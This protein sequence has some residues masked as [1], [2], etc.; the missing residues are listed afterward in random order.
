M[1]HRAG[2]DGNERQTSTNQSTQSRLEGQ[3]TE[4]SPS[5]GFQSYHRPMR[6]GT[7]LSKSPPDNQF[8]ATTGLRGPH[9]NEADG[10]GVIAIGMALG[11]PT[12]GRISS[13]TGWQPQFVTTVTAAK[14][15]NQDEQQ[16]KDGLSRSKSRKWGIFGRSKS[17]RIKNSDQPEQ[18]SSPTTVPARWASTSAGAR[19]MR[20]TDSREA[21]FSPKKKSLGRSFTEPTVS[22]S[23]WSPQVSSPE[24]SMRT[25]L[26]STLTPK[27]ESAAETAN[28]ANQEPMLHVEIPDVTLERYSV[29]FAGLLERR[30]ATSLLARRQV[31]QDKLRALRDD[32]NSQKDIQ[33][34][35]RKHSADRDL[36]PI[37]PLR[38]ES[39]KAPRSQQSS[40]RLRSNTSPAIMG[41][42]SKETFADS[43]QHDGEKSRSP[44]IVRLASVKGSNPL[45]GS[46]IPSSASDR[47]QLRSKFHIQSP[48]H[49]P[50]GSKSTINSSIDLSE[51]DLEEGGLSPPPAQ[52]HGH[53]AAIKTGNPSQT[54]KPSPPLSL[55][56]HTRSTRYTTS[57]D[58]QGSLSMSMS[59]LSEEEPDE[60]QDKAVQDA[61]EISIARQISVSRDQRRMLGPLQMHPIEGRRLAE[62]KSSTPRLVDPRSD[63]SSP[64]AGHRNSERVVLERV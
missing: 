30:S 63:P 40:S 17:K 14:D 44:H 51:R 54:T 1:N 21:N 48:T 28:S 33:P 22:D 16:A 55:Q 62:T 59:S 19:G 42:P 7:V 45:I 18:D 9:V 36:P 49:E 20:Q 57:T 8:T 10:T 60:D 58:A 12:E 6:K 26:D 27:R 25:P 35:R 50:S 41:T 3:E 38:L 56:Q 15:T 5:G 46:G 29:M 2:S 34:S 43:H 31:T 32:G 11:S 24:A 47:P 64:F 23:K 4:K 61:I 37:P 13:G 52:R 39:L 53:T